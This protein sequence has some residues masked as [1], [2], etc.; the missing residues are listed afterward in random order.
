MA[1]A[2]DWRPVPAP[3]CRMAAKAEGMSL[4]A[5]QARPECTPTA[6]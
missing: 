4:A 1:P 3:P 6:A 5:P 2:E